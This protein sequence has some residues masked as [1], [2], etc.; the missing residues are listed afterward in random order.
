M[1][2]FITILAFVVLCAASCIKEEDRDS[3]EKCYPV[4]T[5][6]IMNL[7]F[8]TSENLEVQTGT[9]AE[10]A[11]A[12]ENRVHDLFVYLFNEDGERFYKYYFTYEHMVASLSTLDDSQNECWYVDN[13]G[14]KTIGAVKMATQS[15]ENCTLVVIANVSNTITSLDGRDPIDRL[16]EIDNLDDLQNVKVTLEQEVVNRS[17]LFLMVGVMEN[18]NTGSIQWGTWNSSESS[19][20]YNKV[21]SHYQVQLR[22]VDAKVK[23]YVTFDKTNFN[24]DKCSP[25]YWQ[26]FNAPTSCY[27]FE[28]SEDPDDVNYFNTEE[29]YFEGT[30]T[31]GTG[32]EAKTWKVFT[33]YMLENRQSINVPKSIA[34]DNYYL[35]ELQEKSE[36]TDHP[37]YVKNGNWEYAPENGTYVQFD[38]V[39]NLTETGIQNI[40]STSDAKHALTSEGLY[41][42]HLGD[43]STDLD[44][45]DVKRGHFYKY[46]VTVIN[47]SKIYVE[48]IGDP[49]NGGEI[50]E[51]QPGQEGSLLLATDE[52]VNCDAHYESHSMTFVYSPGISERS[53]SWY[54]KTPFSE[55]GATWNDNTNDWDFDC[56][57][58]LWVKFSVNDSYTESGQDYYRSIRMAYPGDGEYNPSWLPSSGN[59][60]PDLMDIHQL[61]LYLFDQTAKKN[62]NLANDFKLSGESDDGTTTGRDESQVIRVTAFIDEFYYE[63]DPNTYTL[64]SGTN[65]VNPDSGELVPDLWREF[66]NAPPRELHIL[67][68]AQYSEDRKSDVIT[69][70]HSII[71]ES[72]QTFYNT[73]S[74]DLTS[75]WG[76]EH[77]DEMSYASRVANDPSCTAW[78]WLPSDASTPSVKPDDAENG[79]HN[80]AALWGLYSGSDQSWSTYMNYAQENKVPEL[81][82][83]YQYLA[84][85]CLTRNR[86]N[87]GNGTID[88]EELRW[89]TASINQLVGMWVGNESLSNSARLYQPIDP[90]STSSDSREW[91]SWVISSTAS[92]V[93]NP[94]V[95]RAEEGATRSD[96]TFYNWAKVGNT[97][98][99]ADDR[100]KISSIR[101][102]RNI[103]TFQKEGVTTDISYADYDW[104]VDQYYDIPAGTDGNGKARPNADG[105][106]TVRFSR[107]NPRSIRDYTEGDFPSHSEYSLHNCV[108]LEMNMQ[109]PTNYIYADGSLPVTSEEVLNDNITDRGYNEYC[110]RGYRLPNMTELLLMSSI[111]PSSYWTNDKIYPCRTFYSRGKK[112]N[113]TSSEDKKIGWGF[114]KSTGR[115]SIVDQGNGKISGIRCVRDKNSVGEITGKVVVVNGDK[116]QLSTTGEEPLKTTVKLN[117]SSIGSGITNLQL[118]LVY[119]DTDGVEDGIEIPVTGV[120]LSGVSLIEDLEW[121]LPTYDDVPVLGNLVVRASLRNSAGITRTFE[122]PV[123]VISPVFTSVRLMHCN[124][125]ESAD[126]PPFPV[127]LTATSPSEDI[128]GIKLN[129]TSPDGDLTTIDSFVV[130]SDKRHWSQIYNYNYT[131]SSLQ[132]GTYSFQLEVQTSSG[133][134]RSEYATMEI[135]KVNYTP[136]PEPSPTWS[137]A[138]DITEKWERQTIGNLD[139]YAGDFI[140]ANM[141]ISKCVYTFV[142]KDDKPA[143][144]DDSKSLWRDNLLSIGFSDTDYNSST[145]VANVLHVFYP[146]HEGAVDTNKDWLQFNPITAAGTKNEYSYKAFSIADNNGFVEQNSNAKPDISAKQHFRIEKS[147]IY[148]NQQRINFSNWGLSPKPANAEATFEKLISANTLY[149]GSTVGVHRSRA[150]YKFVRAV[151]NSILSNATGGDDTSFEHDPNP[152]GEL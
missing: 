123:R 30:E 148:W 11:A 64:I 77:K 140:E 116:L 25:R 112:G 94:N 9:K 95:V 98:F 130:D 131:M 84:Y 1:K 63:K 104:M 102:L 65:K 137:V 99:S 89:Y 129:I 6:V 7:S 111:Q 122:T 150:S 4:G 92:T 82:S 73:Y 110:P 39:L 81:L 138:S 83:E 41:T 113:Q 2:R 118:S 48:V 76:T 24:V 86:D 47:S 66:V 70:S 17:D 80:S 133:F 42:V 144:R 61:I 141:D 13:S 35:R 85:S 44:D 59:P 36:D 109:D 91:R 60:R 132:L 52:L 101:C 147:G 29:I 143:E 97:A 135:L 127:L 51:D 14:S 5:P 75:L 18:V 145:S 72:I 53:V 45:Y 128:S 134:T 93:T 96:H 151:H 71:Q 37:G 90:S 100:N 27:L 68:D 8:G 3:I 16:S 74:P 54:V 117:F 103:G 139:F 124:Y 152:G 119:V 50:R 108:Y 34:S 32:E 136:N 120:R 142:A 125:N 115:L 43:F 87:D 21:D 88:P 22:T 57:D 46:Y 26:V 31:I 56:K 126:N 105:T 62:N 58:Y 28:H 79:R 33:F 121:V 55:G 38:M 149:I 107:L 23:F 114:H 15:Q 19:G 49:Q 106:Y 40:L 10:A 20:E 146:E 78:D 69:S 12:D 67:S